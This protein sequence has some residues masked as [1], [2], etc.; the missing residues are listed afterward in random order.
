MVTA[1]AGA[2]NVGFAAVL[3]L[4]YRNVRA[5]MDRI[6]RGL[7]TE[8]LPSWNLSSEGSFLLTATADRIDRGG[9]PGGGLWIIDYKTGKAPSADQ[10]AIDA[11]AASM[12]VGVGSCGPAV[13]ST[14]SRG[15]G[16]PPPRI[17]RAESVRGRRW[18]SQSVARATK[19]TRRGPTPGSPACPT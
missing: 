15:M 7:L 11:L 6:V 17:V 18:P 19:R 16:S 4:V 10:V 2:V 12:M 14:V 13:A 1:T 9:G 3:L 8:T 5:P